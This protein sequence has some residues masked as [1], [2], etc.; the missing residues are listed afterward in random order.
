MN[1]SDPKHFVNRIHFLS[2]RDIKLNNKRL[3]ESE[4]EDFCVMIRSFRFKS[5]DFFLNTVPLRKNIYDQTYDELEFLFFKEPALDK[6]HF[7]RVTG[8]V[9]NTD[10]ISSSEIFM[11]IHYILCQLTKIE[12]YMD[13]RCTFLDH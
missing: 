2:Y 11:N 3:H 4:N 8:R 12:A 9:L 13:T 7:L 5:L 10:D 1:V 6:T